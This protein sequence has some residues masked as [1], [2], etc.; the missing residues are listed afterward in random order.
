MSLTELAATVL[1]DGS[2]LS[3]RLGLT[4]LS[5]ME[6]DLDRLLASS[7]FPDLDIIYRL[8]GSTDDDG[9]IQRHFFGYRDGQLVAFLKYDASKAVPYISSLGYVFTSDD[10][11]RLGIAQGMCQTAID[12]FA[13]QGGRASFLSGD[14]GASNVYSQVGFAQLNGHIMR[15]V[16][17][18]DDESFD[19]FYFAGRSTAA[20]RD[21]T[22][23]D[24]AMAAVLYG[25]PTDIHIRDYG[26]Q[27]YS[28]PGQKAERFQS[29][30]PQLMRMQEM[31]HGCVKVVEDSLG[32]LIG[33]AT[34]QK[35]ENDIALVDLLVHPTA[36]DVAPSLLNEIV[37][38]AE[39]LGCITI[40]AKI[41][42]VD[43]DKIKQCQAAGAVVVSES[44]EST[45]LNRCEPV[46]KMQFTL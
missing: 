30:V 19:A 35:Q 23:A 31:E 6:S 10:A 11:R 29:V 33:I 24:W 38:T 8:L 25:Q 44:V 9:S 20:I 22:W 21:L 34:L 12:D 15:C 39:R 5:E 27:L 45:G 2:T 14:E 37:R 16:V 26:I 42:K 36:Q 43:C 4:G 13:R 41:A 18:G 40:I 3:I 17:D 46:A 32:H 1:R 7:D 28:G